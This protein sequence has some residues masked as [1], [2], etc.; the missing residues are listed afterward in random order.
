MT[1][2]LQPTLALGDRRIVAP[3]IAV[4]LLAACGT[5]AGPAAGE[6]SASQRQP[7]P[8]SVTTTPTIT[9][10]PAAPTTDVS[11]STTPVTTIVP[12]VE[13]ADPAIFDVEATASVDF[14]VVGTESYRGIE[15]QRIKFES[16]AGGMAYGYLAMPVGEPLPG[17]G[18]LRAHGA[19]VDGTDEFIPMVMMACAGV[20]SLV[21]DAPYARP[22][23]N[24]MGEAILFNEDDRTEQVQLIR[25]MRRGLDLLAGLGVERFGFGGLS[26]GAA[27]GGLLLGVEPRIEV[28]VLI[29]GDGG[30]VERFFDE[31]GEPVWPLS[32]L[33]PDEIEM[34][35]S[36]MLP[37]EPTRFIGDSAADILF[38]NGLHDQVIP[39]AEAQR[40][41]DAAPPGSEMF[42][43]DIDH[44][45]PFDDMRD[46][47]N[48][49]LGEKLGMDL[50]RLD[51]CTND[52][53]PNGWDDL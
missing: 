3:I 52:L 23:A 29:V 40:Y 4:A 21:I 49:F 42:W 20:V 46:I 30:L 41:F 38:M 8:T 35:R 53:F 1:T 45:I 43:M 50:E 44:D 2:A 11:T 16:P 25:D 31:E 34:W 6:S 10:V 9:E 19:P 15:I 47:H 24:R 28:A 18:V 33:E 27:M 5:G 22:G 37:V 7:D 12:V 39:P 51:R 14:E 48:H 17:V 13:R 26:Y 36:A 32:E